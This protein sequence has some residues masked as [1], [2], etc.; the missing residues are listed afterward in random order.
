MV[1]SAPLPL[2]KV[3][4][5]KKWAVQ[6]QCEVVEL[7]ITLNTLI[8][9]AIKKRHGMSAAATTKLCDSFCQVFQCQLNIHSP[10]IQNPDTA[11]RAFNK[12][13]WLPVN[14]QLLNK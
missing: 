2:S 8:I 1:Y 14:I 12:P 5:R 3:H 7:P 6:V 13:G 11:T 4:K 9:Y 10:G